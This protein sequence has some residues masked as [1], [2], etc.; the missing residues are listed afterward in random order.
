MP[1]S[2][3][4]VRHGSL[5]AHCDVRDVAEVSRQIKGDKDAV[6]PP[7]SPQVLSAIALAH[8]QVLRQLHAPT[9]YKAVQLH[10]AALRQSKGLS[11]RL[12]R[13]DSVYAFLR[14]D[15]LGK[16]ESL[17]GELN[18]ID[19]LHDNHSSA[20]G[21]GTSDGSG[22]TLS[23]RTA[24][25]PR[26]AL[27]RDVLREHVTSFFSLDDECEMCNKVTQT[28]TAHGV[29]FEDPDDTESRVDPV[30]GDNYADS[31][32]SVGPGTPVGSGGSERCE[33]YNCL[34]ESEGCAES[35]GHNPFVG[36]GDVKGCDDFEGCDTFMVWLAEW[37]ARFV[38]NMLS[39]D[40]Y[41]LLL[42]DTQRQTGV[43]IDREL[44]LED[45]SD[46]DDDLASLVSFDE[47]NERP[48]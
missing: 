20:D 40:A 11:Q 6:H 43:W 47:V 2:R 45:L 32:D 31:D 48:S 22:S 34:V 27:V 14:H 12:R 35:I 23:S 16:I 5:L 29:R 9:M 39:A 8:E 18:G 7:S 42:A 26:T 37:R 15:P 41:A 10:S 38:A 1:A 36:R 46:D 4:T 30:D 24:A 17:L 44:M 13:L 19:F 21:S 25:A 3:V 33:G 28:D